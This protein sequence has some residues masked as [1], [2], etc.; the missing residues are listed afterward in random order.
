MAYNTPMGGVIQFPNIH[1]KN[2]TSSRT[3]LFLVT[4]VALVLYPI[5]TE[6]ITIY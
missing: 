4:L 2:Q 1:N 3:L 6:F 5:Y